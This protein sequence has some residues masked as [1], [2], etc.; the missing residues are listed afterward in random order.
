MAVFSALD[1]LIGKY[2][3]TRAF[4]LLFIFLQPFKYLNTVRHGALVLVFLFLFIS[5][6][7]GRGRLDFRD[8]TVQAFG[9][10]IAVSVLSSLLSP[11]AL[12]SFDS[13]RK[14][15]LYQA[16]IFIAIINEFRTMDELKPLFYAFFAGFAALSLSIFFTKDAHVLLNWLDYTNMKDPLLLG[17]SLFATFYIPLGIAYLYAAK[18][19]RAVKG[20]LIFFLLMEFVF[21]LLNNHRTQIVAFSSAALVL[22]A[23]S[24]R[25]KALAGIIIL[26]IVTGVV[27]VRIKP[28][29]FD[30]YRTLA[31]TGTY[32]NNEHQ[33]LNNRLAIWTGTADMIRERP[34]IGYG[35]GWKKLSTVAKDRFMER[36]KTAR[37]R[38]ETYD[39]FNEKGYGSANPHNLLLQLL[40]ETGISGAASFVFFWATVVYKAASRFRDRSEGA[41]FLRYSTSGVLL[42]Y[43]VINATN[44]L[45]QEAYGNLMVAFAACSFVLYRETQGV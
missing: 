30:R 26:F 44:G 17:Y 14:N 6:M 40:F 20:A 39:Y 13:L 7:N 27:L 23:M 15:L 16:V 24:R 35:Y 19:K 43:L 25:Y 29:S 22:T 34:F 3:L 8:R 2:R 1:D 31:S 36:W 10:I 33:A 42:S 9:L 4:L 11:Y 21:S 18:D 37:D 32:I 45:W 28:D 12:E 38:R 5:F 41:V